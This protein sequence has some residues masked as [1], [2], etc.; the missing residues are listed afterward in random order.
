MKD[1]LRGEILKSVKLLA[2]K[3]SDIKI[4]D[5]INTERLTEFSITTDLLSYDFSKQRITKDILDELLTIPDKINL[6]K[7]ISDISSGQFL[8]TTEDRKVSHMLTRDLCVAKGAGEQN[9]ILSQRI[10][11]EK[12]VKRIS[13]ESIFEV[14]TIISI[15]IGGSRLGPEFLSEV[16]NDPNS[17]I[18]IFYCSSFDL[19]ELNKIISIS[20]PSKT[21]VVISSKSFTTP[22]VIENA[23]AVKEWLKVSEGDGWRNNLFGVS[24]NKEG[25]NKFGIKENNQFDL[26]DSIGGRYSIWSSVSFPAIFDMSWQG[27]EQFLEGAQEADKHFIEKPWSENIP[28]LMA[29]ISFW[30]LN[31]LNI[32]NLGIFTYNYRIRSLTKY[33]SQMMMESNGKQ[34]SLDGLKTDFLTCPLVWGGFGPDAQHSNFQWLMQGRDYSACDFIGINTKS[35]LESKSHRMMLAQIVAMSIGDN[36]SNFNHKSVEGNN[37]V[38]LLYLQDLSPYSLGYLLAIYEHKVFTESRIYNI[39]AFDQWGV[40]L[41][42]KLTSNSHEGS[43]YM[44]SYFKEDF[45]S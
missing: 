13:E 36:K 1:D 3:N 42:K 8:N 34:T 32:N 29:L 38:S 9:Q 24:S 33:I 15:G 17:K 30:N 40:Q 16:F 5:I 44:N 10:K 6:K 22:E 43:T 35:D 27:F 19:I 23:N 20:D 39:N 11:L 7:S 18:K 25:M 28:V 21:L 31:G 26:L 2:S 4:K 45:L 41:G 12:F 14:N 37:P